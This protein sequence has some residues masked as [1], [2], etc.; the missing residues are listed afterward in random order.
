MTHYHKG[1][2]CFN[3]K[4]PSCAAPK[5][6][7]SLSIQYWLPP[8]LSL[9]SY[10]QDAVTSRKGD[11]LVFWLIAESCG[12]PLLLWAPGNTTGSAWK[13]KYKYKKSVN[14]NTNIYIQIHK[15]VGFS[16]AFQI[17]KH[18]E[19]FDLGDWNL[20]TRFVPLA[21]AYNYLKLTYWVGISNNQSLIS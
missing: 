9:N 10:A 19:F 12:L 17:F 20:I 15:T 16:R 4:T 7:R 3:Q 6:K 13:H 5:L 18:V 21:S 14:T 2:K 8:S 1:T 11:V